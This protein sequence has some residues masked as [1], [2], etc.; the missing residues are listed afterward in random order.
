MYFWL[1]RTYR[2]FPMPY[3]LEAI[4]MQQPAADTRSGLL[5][6]VLL[7]TSCKTRPSVR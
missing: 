1:T 6:M 3:Q 5:P 4:K 7:A 2:S